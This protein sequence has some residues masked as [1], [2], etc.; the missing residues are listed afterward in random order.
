MDARHTEVIAGIEI[1]ANERTPLI[2]RLLRKI[3]EME[4]EIRRLTD[5]VARLRGHSQRPQIKPSTLHGTTPPSQD[6]QKKKAKKRRKGKR[7]GSAK[8]RKTQDLRIDETIFRHP[9]TLPEGSLLEGYQDLVVQD[10]VFASHNVK[11]RLAKYQL[12][13]GSYVHG[14]LPDQ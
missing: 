13:D 14:K 1:P 9:E 3:V 2:D 8:R 11:Y 10:L 4:G 7:P 5:E 6:K 12:P